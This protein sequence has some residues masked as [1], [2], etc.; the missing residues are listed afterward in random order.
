MDPLLKWCNGEHLLD[1]EIAKILTLDKVST[2]QRDIM[3]LVKWSQ[4]EVWK[5]IVS[6]IFETFQGYKQR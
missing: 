4:N 5:T 6:F 1:I 3:S 2:S